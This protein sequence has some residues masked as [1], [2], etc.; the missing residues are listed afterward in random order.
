MNR[1]LLHSLIG[2][3]LLGLLALAY[4]AFTSLDIVKVAIQRIGV[5]TIFFA[6]VFL[7]ILVGIWSALGLKYITTFNKWW[8][9][10]G[11]DLKS[12]LIGRTISIFESIK[13]LIIIIFSFL[14]LF[15]GAITI[16]AG[17]IF[18]LLVLGA[19]AIRLW[20]LI[21]YCLH[22][23]IH[24]FLGTIVGKYVNSFLSPYYSKY[25]FLVN[26]GETIITSI[27]FIFILNILY[28]AARDHFDQA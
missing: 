28:H 18:A 17:I 24:F 12:K 8:E 1:R 26:Y 11:I 25:P 16:V 9:T 14:A 4:N 7:C 22:W 13:I 19:L 10:K 3:L 20:F 5:I 27:I 2:T 6:G 21:Y 15:L 23:I